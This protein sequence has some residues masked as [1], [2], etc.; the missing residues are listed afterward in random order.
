MKLTP[1]NWTEFQHY[2]DRRPIWIKL[3]CQLLDDFQF[4]RLQVASKALAPMLWLLASEYERGEIT[5]SPEEIAFRLRMDE[6]ECKQALK[7]LIDNGFFSADEE[8]SNLLADCYQTSIP[9]KRR[10]ET[11]KRREEHLSHSELA[12]YGKGQT[13]PRRA[14]ARCVSD[15]EFEQ[16]WDA[17]PKRPGNSKASALKA[18]TARIK[19]GVNPEDILS[20]VHR[21]ARYC[22]ISETPPQYIKQAATFL[23][24]GEHYLADWTATAPQQHYTATQLANRA[25]LGLPLGDTNEQGRIIEMDGSDQP[26]ILN[27]DWRVR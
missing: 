20:G 9:E 5:C 2:K 4:H 3:H 24:P 26:D 6:E 14:S 1:K 13:S 22:R 23:G 7:P 11:E 8:Y 27:L 25:A 19:A 16:V 12:E 15:E 18:Y 21:Y 17:Y 10:E